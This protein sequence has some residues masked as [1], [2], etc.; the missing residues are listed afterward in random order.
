MKI[1]ITADV[2]LASFSETPERY[3]ALEDMINQV[4]AE[5]I[6]KLFIC[7]DLFHQ[8]F[9]NYTDFEKLARKY[10][11]LT[12]YIIPGNHDSTVSSRSLLGPNLK[13]FEETEIIEDAYQLVFIPYIPG[14]TMGEMIA[15]KA[16]QLHPKRWILFSHGDWL[17]GTRAPNPVETGT[18]MPLTRS[19]LEHYQPAKVFLGHIH[20]KLDSPVYYPGSP[21]GMDISETGLRRFLIFDTQSLSVESR[22]VNTDLIYQNCR[23]TI[24]PV[25]NEM[26]YVRKLIAD[27]KDTWQSKPGEIAKTKIRV[28]VQGYTVNKSELNKIIMDEFR[29]YS[30][31]KNET[32]NLERVSTTQDPNRIKIAQLVKENIFNLNLNPSPDEPD[33]DQVLLKSLSIIFED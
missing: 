12:F 32:P 16:G 14:K 20:A 29:D 27:V 26:E 30:Y 33:R 13:V 23:L 2:H 24:L 8:D 21:C 11:Q 28:Q 17:E 31:F 6:D 18:Y 1:A 15:A 5:N 25:E 3:N 9:N 10:P 7:G 19:D 4:L 22:N